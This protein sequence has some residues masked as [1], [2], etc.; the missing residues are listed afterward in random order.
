VNGTE[1]FPN[2]AEAFDS[3]GEAYVVQGDKGLAIE[4]Y[5][6]S[7]ELNPQNAN[8]AEVLKKLRAN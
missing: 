4:N 1:E 7:L 3:L 6:R 5:Q 2:S 8:A